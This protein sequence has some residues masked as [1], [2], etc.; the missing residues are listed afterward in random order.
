MLSFHTL[1]IYLTWPHMTFTYCMIYIP[2]TSNSSRLKYGSSNFIYGG[3]EGHCKPRFSEV[4]WRT[5]QLLEEL[6]CVTRLVF[7]RWMCYIFVILI[8]LELTNLIPKRLDPSSSKVPC[9]ENYRRWSFTES[10]I[11]KASRNSFDIDVNQI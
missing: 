2:S 8:I 6:F 9:W 1:Y 4:F 10:T 3:G 11:L 5:F 7:W